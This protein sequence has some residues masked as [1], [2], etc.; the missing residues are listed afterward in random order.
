[1]KEYYMCVHVFFTLF[2]LSKQHF[3]DLQ[4]RKKKFP[5]N[6]EFLK[7]TIVISTSQKKKEMENLVKLIQEQE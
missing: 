4:K 2:A 1:M 7:Y 5:F 3:Y 6:V